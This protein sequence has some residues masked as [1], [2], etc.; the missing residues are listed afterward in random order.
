M[1]KGQHRPSVLVKHLVFSSEGEEALAAGSERSGCARSKRWAQLAVQHLFTER[2]FS[3]AQKV[4][5]SLHLSESRE[6]KGYR[7]VLEAGRGG[8]QTCFHLPPLTSSITRFSGQAFYLLSQGSAA[9]SNLFLSGNLLKQ[10]P[11]T[12]KGFQ[13]CGH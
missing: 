9:G 4:A 1:T 8:G 10:L 3:A 12:R 2:A 11:S 6:S 13:R 5:T 7:A